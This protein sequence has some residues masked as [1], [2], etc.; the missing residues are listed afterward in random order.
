VYHFIQFREKFPAQPEYR[1]LGWAIFYVVHLLIFFIAGMAM[2]GK[3]KDAITDGSSTHDENGMDTENDEA[4]IELDADF[5]R[6]L[7]LLI[8]V[9][10]AMAYGWILVVK[11][12]SFFSVSVSSSH[13]PFLLFLD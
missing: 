4:H 5:F 12:V 3:N 10:S 7:F 6:L 8:F 2:Y 11:W 13:I 1:D 9:G